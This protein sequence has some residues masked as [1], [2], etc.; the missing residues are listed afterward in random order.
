MFVGGQLNTAVPL[1]LDLGTARRTGRR[2]LGRRFRKLQLAGM[3][4]SLAAVDVQHYR[5][6][7]IHGHVFLWSGVAL[8]P[9]MQFK[10]EFA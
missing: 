6:G 3:P 5:G 1:G 2:H 10:N 4:T 7:R 8:K 9:G